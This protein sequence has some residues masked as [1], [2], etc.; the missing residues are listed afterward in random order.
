MVLAMSR[1]QLRKGSRFPRL[2][3]RV[4]ADLIALVGQ[5]EVTLSL[6]TSDPKE[7]KR[8]HAEE[9]AK[10]E[11][12][13]DRLRQSLTA[14]PS[15]AEDSAAISGPLSERAAGERASWMYAH[16]L[17]LHRENP[18]QQCFWP[19]DLYRH[20]WRSSAAKIKR[21]EDGRTKVQATL[22][23]GQMEKVREL[24]AWCLD[25][26]ETVLDLHDVETDEV[27]ADRVARAIAAQVQRA[28]LTLASL[29]RGEP[30]ADVNSVS[31]P[32]AQTAGVPP[33]SLTGLL[34]AWWSEAQAAGRKPST[35]ESY[36]N[37]LAA[38]VAHL[39]HDDAGRV[40]GDHVVA[41]KDHRLSTPSKRTGKVPSAKTVKDS[42]LAALKTVFGWAVTNRKL[43][44]NPAAGITIKLGKAP[45]LRSKGFTDAE[46][47]TILAAARD[48]QPGREAPKTAAA[49]RWVP[50][51]C[52]FTG[53][54]VGELAQLRREDV[55]QR[56]GHWVVRITPEAGTVKTNEAR[57]I[58]LHR[59][60]V[61]LGFPAFVM[62]APEGHLFLKPSATGD[63][64][65]PLQGLKNRLVEFSRALVPDADVAPNHGWRHRF[66]TV[67]ME[68]E[69]AP[70]I[71]DA[72]QG[73]AARSV[74]DSYG[75]VTLKTIASAID[76]FP[77]IKVPA[78]RLCEAGPS[79]VPEEGKV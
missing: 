77:D 67:G 69:V 2:R 24:E 25:H 28:S 35:Y 68:A 59:Q 75:N 19:T 50:W 48:F 58:V 13:W 42:D 22:D 78:G 56:D 44:A 64:L 1:P 52:A 8:L 5:R 57:E 16:W 51:L 10:L 72:I 32:P 53:G 34:A 3:R 11:A 21:N 33:I 49:K 38:F 45:R 46:A 6:R 12:E 36:R 40:T 43:A 54:R 60:V 9:S 55:T 30:I 62:D 14:K 73:Q 74:A 23:Y 79:A 71:L 37:T 39:G 15:K 76:R 63:V 18:S 27:S 4:P 70:R 41:F 26:A 65:G 61:A 7:A 29:S 66:K 20:L 17:G 47:V 31:T